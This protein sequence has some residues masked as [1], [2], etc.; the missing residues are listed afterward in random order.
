MLPAACALD[1]PSLL[2]FK[3]QERIY[4]FLLRESL[5]AFQPI[6]TSHTVTPLSLNQHTFGTGISTSYTSSYSRIAGL[7]LDPTYPKTTNVASETLRIRH[8]GFPPSN[9]THTG[10][11]TSGRSSPAYAVTFTAD[12]T[13]P[14]HSHCCEFQSSVTCLSLDHFWR[15]GF[16]PVRCYAFFKRW[17]LLSQLPGCCK[18]MTSLTT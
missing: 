6:Y 17:L 9:A 8:E 7:A 14:Y 3:T 13:L 18:T 16:R 11:L 5:V 10:I 12:R 4:Q 2:Q 1:S 15:H